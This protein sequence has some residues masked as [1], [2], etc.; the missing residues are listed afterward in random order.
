MYNDIKV[1]TDK[2]LDKGKTT[3]IDFDIITH[4]N[5]IM[6]KD[7]DTSSGYIDRKTYGDKIHSGI[8]KDNNRYFF[9]EHS[10]TNKPSSIYTKSWH[11]YHIYQ[12]TKELF[13]EISK[14][15]KFNIWN[16]K[17]NSLYHFGKYILS[18]RL[19][20]YVE[21]LV[22]YSKLEN[23]TLTI[24]Y[25]TSPSDNMLKSGTKT[26]GE[27]LKWHS[28][29]YPNVNDLKLNKSVIRENLLNDILF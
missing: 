10:I 6:Y 28:G 26:I 14:D 3:T 23:D 13:E 8:T 18:I 5:A 2:N 11:S 4:E 22:F 20:N 9:F 25:L 17:F 27:F 7:F 15:N 1:S 16:V 12:I 29:N 21:N 24:P 19:G